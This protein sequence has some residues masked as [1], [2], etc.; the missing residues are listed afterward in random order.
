MKAWVELFKLYFS[1]SASSSA[2]SPTDQTDQSDHTQVPPA[3]ADF[4]NKLA[5]LNGHPPIFPPSPPSSEDGTNLNGSD[6]GQR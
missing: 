5:Q 3:V 2:F 1:R 6:H 4:A